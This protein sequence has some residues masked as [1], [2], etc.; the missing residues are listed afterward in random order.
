MFYVLFC[1]HLTI[2]R[3]KLRDHLVYNW[4][5]CSQLLRLGVRRLYHDQTILAVSYWWLSLSARQ[6]ACS[7]AHNSLEPRT[8]RSSCLAVGVYQSFRLIIEIHRV[9]VLTLCQKEW[10]VDRILCFGGFIC[11]IGCGFAC[12]HVAFYFCWRRQGRR[13]VLH[14][15]PD[16]GRTKSQEIGL[17]F[18]WEFIPLLNPS[19]RRLLSPE[20]AKSTLWRPPLY[21]R[22]DTY[23]RFWE[24]LW[25]GEQVIPNIIQVLWK[26]RVGS[27]DRAD[28]PV[29][30]H[31]GEEMSSQHQW[32]WKAPLENV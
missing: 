26:A 13:N 17:S 11:Q 5:H 6:V 14:L 32:G 20:E 16:D 15:E 18:P 29:V 21:E 23:L 2:I 28:M 24:T 25:G 31:L 10:R 22:R 7:S 3:E 12:V 19:L 30:T 8:V 4:L 27:W 1:I 9:S